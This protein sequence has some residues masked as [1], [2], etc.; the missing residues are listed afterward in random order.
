MLYII[1]GLV[2][3]ILV[4]LIC[5]ISSMGPKTFEDFIKTDRLDLINYYKKNKQKYKNL[6]KK[7]I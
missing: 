1:I 3:V 5:V 7:K 2:F 4:I 6:Y